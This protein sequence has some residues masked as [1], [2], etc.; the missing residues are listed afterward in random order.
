MEQRRVKNETRIKTMS[1][2]CQ[3]SHKKVLFRW[4]WIVKLVKEPKKFSMREKLLYVSKLTNTFLTKDS[5]SDKY[6]IGWNKIN[7]KYSW[8]F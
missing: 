5:R 8:K 4:F 3:F 7:W 2:S 6:E 1:W